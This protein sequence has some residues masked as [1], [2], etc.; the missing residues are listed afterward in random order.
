MTSARPIVVT[1]AT[2]FIGMHV[3]LRLLERGDAVLGVDA[4]T[5]YYDVNLKQRRL[6][7][8]RKY[9]RF[10]F[11]QVD[12]ADRKVS[13]DLFA[14]AD[15]ERIVHLAAQPGVHP[16]SLHAATKRADELMAHSRDFGFRPTTPIELGV[17]RFVE[18]LYTEGVAPVRPRPSA[19]D[20]A[21]PR[22][23]ASAARSG[24]EEPC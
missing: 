4:L 5:P 22:A 15:A 14:G 12:L 9:P 20:M 17:C 18:W 11:A 24:I 23:P 1:G 16:V 7:Q 21:D 13:A 8:L 10:A 3:A 19:R 6:A 2:G